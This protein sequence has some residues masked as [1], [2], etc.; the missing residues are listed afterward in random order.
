[1]DRLIGVLGLIVLLLIAYGVSSNR[2]AIQWRTVLWGLV[3]QFLF[4][5]L[6][7][8]FGF[9]QEVLTV[10]AGGIKNLI[11]YADRGGEFLFGWL[12]SDPD[13]NH[14][15]FAF[16]VLPIVIFISSLF[17]CLY[18]LGIMQFVVLMMARIMTRSMGVSGAESLAT[19]ANV[20]MGQTEAPIIIAPYIQKMTVSE[21][22]ALM[23]GGMATVSGSILGTMCPSRVST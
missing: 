23:T 10:V 8:K 15:V 1:M 2:K 17:T 21:L 19:A 11:G 4:A 14:F 18:Y 20:F 13:A 6:V 12:V 16:K 5:L 3:L 22:M 9:G 7:F